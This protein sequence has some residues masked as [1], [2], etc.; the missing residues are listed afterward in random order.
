MRPDDTHK[1][2]GFYMEV[3]ICVPQRQSIGKS[4]NAFH[5]TADAI[6]SKLFALWKWQCIRS[7]IYYGSIASRQLVGLGT[8]L[9]D[10]LVATCVKAFLHMSVMV[11]D[12]T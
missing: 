3:L 1:L 12:P 9:V 11:S 2:M 10:S 7:C 8:R 5:C 6:K 4:T